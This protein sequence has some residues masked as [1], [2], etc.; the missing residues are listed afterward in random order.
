MTKKVDYVRIIFYI[1]LF[2]VFIIIPVSQAEKSSLCVYYNL[3]GTI[4]PGCGTTRAFSN[5]LHMNLQRAIEYNP[6]FTLG[7][8]PVCLFLF[9]QDTIVIIYRRIF[10]TK[11][12]S[13]LEY[14]LKLISM[15]GKKNV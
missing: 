5:I 13:L 3:S 4:C 15:A 10:K 7:I 2:T 14:G 6:V 9:L 8:A 1:V 11:T 12:I